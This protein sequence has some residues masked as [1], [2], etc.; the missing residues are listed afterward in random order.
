MRQNK[1]SRV[2]K[3]VAIILISLIA[4]VVIIR[5]LLPPI[6][7]RQ[8]NKEIEE[9]EEYG[10]GIDG[11]NL[12]ILAGEYRV[13]GLKLY[14]TE[15]ETSEPFV[16]TDEILI[17]VDY[18]SLLRGSFV[19]NITLIRPVVNL[20]TAPSPEESQ[21]EVDDG[22]AEVADDI[23]PFR[24]ERLIIED[25]R[26]NYTDKTNDPAISIS[27]FNIHLTA[28]NLTNKPTDDMLLPSTVTG[29]ANTTGNGRVDINMKL[30]PFASGPTFDMNFEL[31]EMELV[32]MN[33]LL[34]EYANIE[35]K[36]GT[37]NFHSEIAAKDGKFIG[38]VKPLIHELEIA[39]LE[40]EDKGFF[41]RVWETLASAATSI[42][43]NP[44]EEQIGT[45]I[46]IEGTFENPDANIWQTVITLVRNAFIEALV[47][48]IDHSIHIGKVREVSAD[49]ENE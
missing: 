29:W 42:L 14:K 34:K 28:E 3:I 38:Y 12:S 9:N 18:K 6:I 11:V 20:I 43:E 49:E 40:K 44:E 22:L 48:S 35:V 10:G 4:L 31:K 7:T 47:P 25:G 17:G 26:L 19:G 5:L 46:P 8:I 15:S 13:N 39:P 1:K 21:E 27:V 41:Q 16:T 30:D 36:G 33:Y 37:F 23:A 24:L 2:L 32:E 45:R